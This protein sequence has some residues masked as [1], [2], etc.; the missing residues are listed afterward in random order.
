MGLRGP[1]HVSAVLRVSWTGQSGEYWQ[2]VL[3]GSQGG[4]AAVGAALH[5]HGMPKRLA[6]ALCLEAGVTA[7]PLAQLKKVV[8]RIFFFFST[9]L[10]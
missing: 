10:F 1:A 3:Q 4:A 7:T 6:D 2:R 9:F 5:K 8:G